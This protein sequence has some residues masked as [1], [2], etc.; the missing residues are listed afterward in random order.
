VNKTETIQQPQPPWWEKRGNTT[1]ISCHN[2]D[3][4]FHV[5]L[6]LL[7]ANEKALHCPHCGNR[8]KQEEAGQ[9]VRP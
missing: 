5:S 1:W 9:I 8:F 7:Q 2:C 3:D 4:W 6:G